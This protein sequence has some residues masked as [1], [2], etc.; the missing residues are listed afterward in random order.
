MVLIRDMLAKEKYELPFSQQYPQEHPL[1][2]RTGMWFGSPWTCRRS[3]QSPNHPSHTT[4]STLV[5]SLSFSSCSHWHWRH[6]RVETPYLRDRYCSDC[7]RILLRWPSKR[8]WW[9]RMFALRCSAWFPVARTVT[10][11]ILDEIA[12]LLID[13]SVYNCL[14]AIVNK[15]YPKF[16]WILTTKMIQIQKFSTENLPLV[17]ISPGNLNE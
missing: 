6:Q 1:W 12:R 10:K 7:F 5:I 11:Q 16:H 13:I 4:M 8:N 17:L 14:I 3:I 9:E 2:F 15:L